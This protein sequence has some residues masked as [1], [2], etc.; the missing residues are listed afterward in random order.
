MMIGAPLGIRTTPRSSVTGPTV[1]AAW[2]APATS[3]MIA[4][5]ANTARPRHVFANI[6]LKTHLSCFCVDRPRGT[7]PRRFGCAAGM[8]SLRSPHERCQH[9]ARAHF[10]NCVTP[11]PIH[12]QHILPLPLREGVG[13]RGRGAANFRV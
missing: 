5:A 12:G 6:V 7:P 2:A 3:V 9:L 1:C 8:A 13:G 11:P 4:A 10:A